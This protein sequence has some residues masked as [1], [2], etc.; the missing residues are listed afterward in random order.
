MAKVRIKEEADQ[1]NIRSRF[2]R[3]RASSISV[4][5]GMTITQVVED[6]LRAYQPASRISA[7]HG[8]AREGKLLVL[9]RRGT[10]TITHDEAEAELNEI[11]GG[12]RE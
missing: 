11:R 6:A 12:A 3:A 5:T 4:A 10:R 9:S 7:G 1:L 2:A 8:L